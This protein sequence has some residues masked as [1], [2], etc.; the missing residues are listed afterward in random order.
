MRPLLSNVACP[1][2]ETLS[3]FLLGDLPETQ[4]SEVAAHVSGCAAC[5]EQASRLDSASDEIVECLRRLPNCDLDARLADT[6]PGGSSEMPAFLAETESWGEFRIVREI[7]R[8]G[9]GVVC[10][11]F[12]GSLNRH[13]AIKF[14]PAQ[15]NLARFQREAKAAGRLHHTNIVP[16]FGVG[17]HEGRA[18]YVMQYIAGRGLEGVLHERT[19]QGKGFT[20]GEVARAG[21]QVAD[22]LAYAHSQGVIHRDVKPSNLLMDDKG[23][24]WVTDFGLA[25]D[26]SDT[27][28]L[29][30]TG[31]LLGTLRYLAPERLNGPG[32]SRLDIYGLGVSLYELACRRPAYAETDRAALIHRVMNQ[33]PPPPRQVEPKIAPDLETIILKAMARDPAHRYATAAAMADDLRR[34]LDDRSILARRVSLSEQAVRWCRRNRAVAALLLALVIVLLTGSGGVFWQ[35]RKAVSLARAEGHAAAEARKSAAAERWALYRASMTAAASALQLNNSDSLR[36]ILD[37]AP[38]EHRGW[39]WRHF[40]SELNGGEVL[41]R[42]GAS[43]AVHLYL[44]SPPAKIFPVF[45][46]EQRTLTV[47]DLGRASRQPVRPSCAETPKNRYRSDSVLACSP[48]GTRVVTLSRDGTGRL[49]DVVTRGEIAAL[50]RHPNPISKALFGAQGRRLVT[51]A[52][53]D[54][55]IRLW[56]GETGRDIAVLRGHSREVQQL[57]LG[58]DGK[59]IASHA[60]DNEPVRLWDSTTGEPG[61]VL[62]LPEGTG[63]SMYMAI[64]K[65]GR[66][67]AAGRMR[68]PPVLLWDGQ[69][70]KLLAALPCTWHFQVSPDGARA[71]AAA[72]LSSLRRF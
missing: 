62:R 16:V 7:G 6:D 34:F 23:T 56:D 8:G 26:E 25:H 33:E 15:G 55:N 30:E 37:A 17:E 49:W 68:E 50:S 28:T 64:T 60:G 3:A 22:A 59:W 57:E 72:P 27:M 19:S 42:S 24:V 69:S 40:D 67:V 52:K 10:E 31:D 48:D 43:G 46:R 21:V 12:Q 61:Q 32:D 44:F 13:V 11:A 47:F 66:R 20:S 4:L 54:A 38:A 58:A 65:D 41:S 70:G 39:E 9:M 14:L 2:A 53:G 45:D 36:T 51:I 5:E 29:T 63:G 1:S 71:A 35:W 18:Y